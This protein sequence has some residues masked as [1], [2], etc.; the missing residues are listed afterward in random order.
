VPKLFCALLFAS[1]LSS[2]GYAAAED[3][4][5]G[6]LS[7]G[8]TVTLT[9]NVHRNAQ[10]QFDQGPVDPAMRL[11]TITLLTVP[12]PAQ[13][14]ALTQLL[15][16]QQDRKSPNYH[17]W[18]TPEQYAD[19]FGL[20]QNDMR[21]MAVWL[22]SQGFTM[23][24]SAR[25]RNWISFTGTAA[26]VESAFRTEIHR[27]DVHGELHYANAT[28]PVIPA[29]L[30]G[31]VT[32]LRGL[33][34]FF[35]RPLGIRR[36]PELSNN[37]RPYR[38]R[39]YYDSSVLGDLVA[40]G[41]IATIYDINALYNAG[42]DGTGQKLAVIGQSDIYL[43][44][45]T[46][47][48]T[49]FGLSPISCTTDSNGVITACNDPHLQY[50]LDGTDPGI[51]T[52]G[53]LSEADLDLEW[54]GAIA[55][56]AQLIYVNSTDS[57]TSYYYAID[58]TLAP[59]ISLSY[60]ECEFDDFA[61]TN[62]ST[63][64]PGADE[65]ELMK[66]NSEGITF[67][68]SSGDTGAAECD[69]NSALSPTGLAVNGIAVSYPA[70]SP[71][72]TGVGGTAIP[73]DNLSIE[74]W[75]T[76]TGTDG[77]SVLPNGP[78]HG[79]IP[80]QAWNDDDEF[81]QYCLEQ[82]PGTIE[83]E[84][85]LQGGSTPVSGWVALT[86]VTA[87]QNDIG[88]SSSG[89]GA[90]NC[91]RH[92]SAVCIN[93][94]TQPTWQT[95]AVSG[96]SGVRLSPDVS[97]LA[98]PNFPGYIFCTQ[99][100]ELGDSGTGSSCGSGGSAGITNALNLNFPSIIG[101]TSAS[102]PVFAG[103]VTLLNQYTASAGQGNVNPTLYSL[104]AT[105]SNNVFHPVTTGENTVLCVGGE[106]SN[107][108]TALQCP[109]SGPS[110]GLIGFQASNADATT[111]YNLVAGLGS[112]D[113]NNFAAAF[114]A[115]LPSGFTFTPT[116]TTYTVTPGSSVDATATVAMNGGFTGPVTFTCTDP[117]PEST[118]TAPQS[119]SA[120]AGVSFHIT[121][122]APSSASLP[123]SDRGLRI[124]YAAFLPGV[125]GILFTAG[126][127]RRFFQ[128]RA[129]KRKSFQR[130]GE[131]DSRFLQLV[132]VLGFSTLGL[133]SCGG[134]GGGGGTPNPGT[135]Q[136]TYQITV[137]ATSGSTTSTQT[138]NLVVQ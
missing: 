120:T 28:D 99:L 95:V 102:A 74:Y 41:D 87:A 64:D 83:Y 22:K 119:I 9:G 17:K 53:D 67:V 65:T 121:T 29:A 58:N 25:G 57:K 39:P 70:S 108:P 62:V 35:P 20:T 138:L 122:T 43:S 11:G 131:L 103:I 15:A 111:G 59:V 77:G 133:A 89:G 31:I 8:Q 78:D 49:G 24:Q 124:F 73:L 56:G 136:G 52:N 137:T 96:Q 92:S 75:G 91:S 97:F 115:T 86:S 129:S 18:L 45:I 81:V 113:A 14:K 69:I 68:N 116:A 4:I 10:P 12:T 5:A 123:P 32:G 6:S 60:G 94:F 84:F 93:G 55:R 79:Y 109:S 37:A 82:S 125:L 104:A 7:S 126:S 118:C 135:P 30:G 127:R 66:A 85:C 132:L 16:Q 3:R 106:P 98:T 63:G 130:R 13:Q 38:A 47:F 26:Q 80:E 48:R 2:L 100:S 134:S 90:S 44:D 19:R 27:Y 72:V 51:A 46:N 33:H 61:I 101:G 34:D 110:A 71:E 50:I 21:Q 40:P 107:Q 88:I 36:N 117:A 112:V 128:R 54:S 76:S 42:F 1:I 105:P 23:I 114:A